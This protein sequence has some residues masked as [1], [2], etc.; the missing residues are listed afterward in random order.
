MN[1]FKDSLISD[2]QYFKNKMKSF[3]PDSSPM[4]WE[5]YKEN[6]RLGKL[7][8]LKQ[9][10]LENLILS[11]NSFKRL[12]TKVLD[13]Q[14]KLGG[15]F[16]LAGDTDFNF[17]KL[18]CC[19]FQKI[20]I[21]TSNC[22]EDF[23]RLKKCE[24]YHHKLVNFSLMPVTGGL[25]NFKGMRCERYDRLDTFIYDLDE[26]Y[27]AEV[28]NRDKTRVGKYRSN[29]V[30][31]VYRNQF[32]NQFDDVYD[33]CKQV[34]FIEKEFVNRMINHGKKPIISRDDVVRYMDDALDYWHIK[35]N[36]FNSF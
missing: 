9:F 21:E 12:Q 25:N 14:S 22:D 23:V 6:Y 31:S 18:K 27:S 19:R 11:G 32:L 34:Y 8:F 26:Y 24:E 5:F 29:N 17:N 7:T 1:S 15:E 36:I 20:L 2:Q 35:F 10:D 16:K 3:D 30:N 33:Y 28:S 4:T 13:H